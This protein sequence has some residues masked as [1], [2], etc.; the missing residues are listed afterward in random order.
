MMILEVDSMINDE[1]QLLAY[2]SKFYKTSSIELKQKY[3]ISELEDAY[4]EIHQKTRYQKYLDKNKSF[5]SKYVMK[6]FSPL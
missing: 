3:T 4:N 2:M 5:P 1:E 6:E